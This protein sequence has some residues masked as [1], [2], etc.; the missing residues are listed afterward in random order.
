[1]TTSDLWA[2]EHETKLTLCLAT[3]ELRMLGEE[4][5]TPHLKAQRPCEQRFE[6]KSSLV[7][8]SL[9]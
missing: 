4:V 3:L 8:F 5:K 9:C 7:L 2:N 1:M 6:V